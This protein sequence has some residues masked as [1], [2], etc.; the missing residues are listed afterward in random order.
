MSEH[1]VDLE[2]KSFTDLPPSLVLS[3]YNKISSKN[4]YNNWEKLF[5]LY[6]YSQSWIDNFFNSVYTKDLQLL[7]LDE[8]SAHL[9]YFGCHELPFYS[10]Q[11]MKNY[12]TNIAIFDAIN[13]KPK[14]KTGKE[15]QMRGKK[16]Q[17]CRQILKCFETF[18]Y[19]EK[20]FPADG[21]H[22][23]RRIRRWPTLMLIVD[24]DAVP[25]DLIKIISVYMSPSQKLIIAFQNPENCR[26]F[27][28]LMT[29]YKRTIAK[30]KNLLQEHIH[31]FL[32]CLK[33]DVGGN[34]VN[35]WSLPYL[36]I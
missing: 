4:Q 19:T 27:N 12:I 24:F 25:F 31:W 36:K 9:K 21:Y 13:G 2:R 30:V 33:V 34:I 14:E 5:R 35:F 26:S 23:M 11:L 22:L 28:A 17:L 20:P 7:G 10:F 29:L 15:K 16:S 6:F 8:L 32:W 1:P 3:I 18:N